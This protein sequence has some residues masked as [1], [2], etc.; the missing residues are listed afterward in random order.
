MSDYPNLKEM[1]TE[2]L[3]RLLAEYVKTGSDAIIEEDRYFI[4]AIQEELRA[5]KSG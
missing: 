3:V 1:T 5:R 2:D 4:K